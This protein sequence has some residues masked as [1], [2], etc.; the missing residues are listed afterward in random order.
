MISLKNVCDCF[1]PVPAAVVC[2]M[3]FRD[4]AEA[5][6]LIEANLLMFS[7]SPFDSCSS[8]HTFRHSQ[9]QALVLKNSIL[10]HRS[11]HFCQLQ[12]VFSDAPSSNRKILKKFLHS[13][14]VIPRP[15]EGLFG[16]RPFH[17]VRKRHPLPIRTDQRYQSIMALINPV[18]V[19]AS[20]SRR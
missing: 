9:P 20:D 1:S 14:D 13:G 5:V 10:R 7:S 11:R 4:P 6:V 16:F 2:T 8:R 3:L 17:L 12:I 19:C 15:A 18:S